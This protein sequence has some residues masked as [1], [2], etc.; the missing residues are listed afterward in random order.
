MDTGKFKNAFRLFDEYNSKDP[1]TEIVDG[2]EV[3]SALLYAQRMTDK[4]MDFEPHASEHLQLAARCQHI[5]RWEIPRKEYPMNRTG[6]LQWRSQL[7]IYHAKIASELM[8]KSGY[9]ADSIAKVKDLLLK[10]QLKPTHREGR[11]NPETQLLEDV[12]CM[13]FLQYYF[14]DFSSE[15]QEAN[16]VNI[17]QKTIAKMSDEVLKLPCN[18][19]CQKKPKYLLARLLQVISRS[20]RVD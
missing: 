2:N 17:L 19:P 4:L 10:K 14:D 12:I 5:G 13:V 11:Q 16:L 6:Y 15:H 18:C 7:K 20:L 8:E 9:D 1:K 3:P